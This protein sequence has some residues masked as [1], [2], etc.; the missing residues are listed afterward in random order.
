[1]LIS[2]MVS[3]PF[4]GAQGRASSG[5]GRNIHARFFDASGI[6]EIRG[7]ER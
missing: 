7:G 5:E 3:A 2:S 1:M 4:L 6:K